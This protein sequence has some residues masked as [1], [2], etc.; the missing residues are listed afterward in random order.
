MSVHIRCQLL[1]EVSDGHGAAPFLTGCRGQ[2]AWA[3]FK[4]RQVI[5]ASS[6]WVQ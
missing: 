3:I 5:V 4:Q 1:Q 6:G 2:E